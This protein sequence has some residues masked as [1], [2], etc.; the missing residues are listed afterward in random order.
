[1]P[2]CALHDI[3]KFCTSSVIMTFNLKLHHKSILLQCRLL[4]IYEARLLLYCLSYHLVLVI[5][6]PVRSCSGVITCYERRKCQSHRQ[7]LVEI[8]MHA[9]EVTIKLLYSPTCKYKLQ[10]TMYLSFFHSNSS[11]FMF[12][13]KRDQRSMF[14]E[15]IKAVNT[16]PRV[17]LLYTVELNAWLGGRPTKKKHPSKRI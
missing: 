1:M 7:V 13:S 8:T 14:K 12:I 6:D 16:I 5:M 3:N 10:P 11:K 15:A 2:H 9:I 17:H 4:Y